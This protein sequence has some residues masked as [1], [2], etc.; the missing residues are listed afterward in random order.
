MSKSSSYDLLP[1]IKTYPVGTVFKSK[2]DLVGTG[3]SGVNKSDPDFN[4]EMPD[5]NIPY[6]S[7][8]TF[9]EDKQFMA[10]SSEHPMSAW[11]RFHFI[12]DEKIVWVTVCREVPRIWN[13]E[14]YGGKRKMIFSSIDSMFDLIQSG[15]INNGTKKEI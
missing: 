9:V 14:T 13:F 5:F 7:V 2:V 8:F 3:Y 10:S 12:V 15:D 11:V 4:E 6:G 1:K